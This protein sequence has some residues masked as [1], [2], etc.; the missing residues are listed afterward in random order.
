MANAISAQDAISILVLA[1]EM[2]LNP[3]LHMV[4]WALSIPLPFLESNWRGLNSVTPLNVL[5]NEYEHAYSNM[6]RIDGKKSLE[7]CWHLAKSL[8]SDPVPWLM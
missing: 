4:E 7:M 5:V 8:I 6:P 2:A 3:F 1:I